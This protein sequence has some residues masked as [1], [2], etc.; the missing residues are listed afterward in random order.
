MQSI[1]IFNYILDGIPHPVLVK[2]KQHRFVFV[3]EAMCRLMAKARDE[4]LGRT[5]FDFFPADLARG[6]CALDDEVMATGEEREIE[7]GFTATDGRDHILRTRKQ[8]VTLPG[9]NGD[10]IYLVASLIDITDLRQLQRDLQESEKGIRAIADAVPVVIWVINA[11]NQLIFMNRVWAGITGRMPGNNL[12]SEWLEA[13]HPADR[14]RALTTVSSATRRREPFRVEYRLKAAHGAYMSV[15]DVGQPRYADDGAYLGYVGSILDISE[16][17]AAEAALRESEARNRTTAARL[18]AVLESTTDSV[19]VLDRDWR[20]TYLNQRAREMLAPYDVDIGMSIWEAFPSEAEGPFARRY[21]QA[22]QDR[23]PVAFEE[24]VAVMDMWLEVHAYP[25]DGGLSIFYRDV[26]ERRQAEQE[27]LQ[28]QEQI[29][30]MAR[31]DLL[32][33]LPNRQQFRERLERS[34]AG[35]GEPCAA[36]H[37]LDLDGFKPVNDTLGHA[38]GDRLLQLVAERLQNSVRGSD[39]VARFGGDEFAVLQAGAAKREE[40]ADLAQ[41]IT[42]SL[43][44]P[45]NIDGQTASIGASVGI[46]MAPEDGANTDQLLKAADIALYSAKAE[47]HGLYRFF[48]RG[49]DELVRARQSTREALRIALVQRQLEVHYQPLVD[50]ETGRLSCFEALLRWRH[51]QQGLIAPSEFIPLAEETRLIIPIGEFVLREACAL[52]MTWPPDIGVAVNLSPV[53]FKQSGLVETVSKVLADTG[54]AP[55]RL[56]LEITESVLLEND[57]KN[58]AVLQKLRTLGVSIAMDDFGTGYSSLSYLRSFPFDKI[59]L[60]RSFIQDLQHGAEAQAIVHAMAGLGAGLGIT[61]T[62]EGVETPEQLSTLRQEGYHEGQG[63]L[64]GRPVPAEDVASLI[65]RHIA[66][67]VRQAT[68]DQAEPEAISLPRQISA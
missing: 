50:L 49:M 68:G 54:L 5:D 66:I 64:F 32:T 18:N 63:Y 59:K 24:Y 60:D 34:L 10:E 65:M 48:E 8:S 27:R 3:N 36:V 45:F 35:P 11:E 53:Q 58:V 39:C 6:Y 38:A 25:T 2:D 31:H 14:D 42:A 20:V 52:A 7:E 67:D 40:A 62:A 12:I 43:S 47:G 4:V 57:R 21:R 33:G 9:E 56:Q 22:V 15:L 19:M 61:M 16:R 28:A 17:L 37:F 29:T 41:R 44:E 13:I 30:H 51:P 23:T 46:A 55:A 1:E 26:S